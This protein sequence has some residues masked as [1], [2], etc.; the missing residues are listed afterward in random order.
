M[1]Y[2]KRYLKGWCL[3]A[4]RACEHYVREVPAGKALPKNVLILPGSVY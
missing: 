1:L 3:Y 2:A 4:D